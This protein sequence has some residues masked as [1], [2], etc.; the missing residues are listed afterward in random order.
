[1]SYKNS[2]YLVGQGTPNLRFFDGGQKRKLAEI[3]CKDGGDIIYTRH[4]YY[5][6][7]TQYGCN[8]KYMNIVGVI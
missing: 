1:M 8:V 6:N 7:F 5:T 4:L 3:F 2:F